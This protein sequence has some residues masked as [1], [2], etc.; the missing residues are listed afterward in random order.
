[1]SSDPTN[2]TRSLP[3]EAEANEDE[4]WAALGDDAVPPPDPERP[5]EPRPEDRRVRLAR[6]RRRSL[7]VIVRDIIMGCRYIHNLSLS[8]C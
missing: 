7:Q 4:H 8:N 5:E 6:Q 3:L 1:M 2:N